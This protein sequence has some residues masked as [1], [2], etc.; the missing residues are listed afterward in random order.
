[1]RSV[2]FL[3][4]SDRHCFLNG[5]SHDFPR[6]A[7]DRQSF[8]VGPDSSSLYMSL[9]RR[10]QQQQNLGTLAEGAVLVLYAE[11]SPVLEGVEEPYQT[12]N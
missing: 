12:V 6:F 2:A 8:L 11:E 7:I 4:K 1:M 10:T 5:I 3:K 9:Q